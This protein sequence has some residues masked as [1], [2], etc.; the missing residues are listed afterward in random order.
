MYLAIGETLVSDK[1]GLLVGWKSDTDIAQMFGIQEH[2][3]TKEMR[4]FAYENGGL[5]K[6]MA[7]KIG[8]SVISQL[9]LSK[10]KD[11]ETSANEFEA[12]VADI[13]N[14]ALL[15]AQDQKLVSYNEVSSNSLAK[16][17][18]DGEETEQ[19]SKTY[20]I[21][22]VG[23][24]DKDSEFDKEVPTDLVHNFIEGYKELDEVLPEISTTKKRGYFT[25]PDSD[26][27]EKAL[28]KENSTCRRR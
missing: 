15:I 22:I 7:N 12:L 13:G 4:T 11:L 1:R 27:L 16:M 14:M 3:I 2:E 9:G 23:Q 24:Q 8:K 21:K 10:R 5:L 25:P 26:R 17:Y 19:D 6:T 18:R 20:F 28:N